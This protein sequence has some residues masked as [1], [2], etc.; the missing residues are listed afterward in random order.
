MPDAVLETGGGGITICEVHLRRGPGYGLII[1]PCTEDDLRRHVTD[2]ANF[3][4]NPVQPDALPDE[5][6]SESGSPGM[7]RE[8]ERALR[9]MAG[10]RRKRAE[11]KPDGIVVPAADA[12][13]MLATT[14]GDAKSL[15]VEILARMEL[16]KRDRRDIWYSSELRKSPFEWLQDIFV[17]VNNGLH[18][19]F[20]LPRRIEVVVPTAVLGDESLAVTL[21]DTQGIDDIAARAD[22][23]QHFDDAHTVVLLCSLF[24]EAPQTQV[25]DLLRRA[26]EGGVRTL[27][28]NA[29]VLVLPRPGDALEMKDNGYPVQTAHEGYEIKAEEV[30][31]KL[32]PFGLSNLPIA[33]FNAAEDA[34]E[35]L[36]S[37]ILARI[38]A[39][40]EFHRN[41]LHEIIRG[42]NALLSNYE[43]EQAREIMQEAAR[44][45]TTWLK[46][47]ADLSKASAR[48]VHESLLSA[49]ATAHPRTI[50]ATVVRKGEWPKLDYA[51]QLSHG[52]RRIATH[53]A[54]SK[55]NDFRAIAV[56]LLHQ[57]QFI[58][59]H[60]LVRQ[61]VRAMEDGFDNLVRKVQLVGQSIHADEMSQDDKFWNDCSQVRGSGYRDRINTR[62][63][64]WF[65]EK[66]HGEADTRVIDV[67]Q[68]EWRATTDSVRAL[69]TQG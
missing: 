18:P 21:I 7:S 55:L 66:H 25:R 14:T 8:I 49:T 33:F 54:E 11:R 17:R 28:S 39:V 26:K 24:G 22:L 40:R 5:Q 19:E 27:E 29:A 69:V 60:D 46:H 56:N 35:V 6:G 37:F 16:H 47:N 12:A 63:K 62:N 57:D 58:D 10:L 34:P 15:S 50:Y 32:H 2:F 36:R 59:A 65:E 43:K 41:A 30:Q 31:L 9:N 48:H 23:E 67:V 38:N 4:L 3:L 53:V 1:E 44:N 45:L 68:E 13:R 51:H 42:A 61:A 64:H 52:A 20:T